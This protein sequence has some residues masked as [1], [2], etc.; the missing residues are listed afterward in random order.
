MATYAGLQQAAGFAQGKSTSGGNQTHPGFT[1]SSADQ[2]QNRALPS[3]YKTSSEPDPL[4]STRES[5]DGYLGL[6]EPLQQST[7]PQG[8][9]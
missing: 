7:L 5:R 8:P 2:W 6:R 4:R 1:I 3:I 9:G